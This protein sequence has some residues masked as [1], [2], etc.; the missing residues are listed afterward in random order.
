MVDLEFLPYLPE[1]F[2]HLPLSRV[3]KLAQMLVN[4]A[5][6]VHFAKFPLHFCKSEAHLYAVTAL[7]YLESALEKL[8]CPCHTVEF[9]CFGYLQVQQLI[10]IFSILQLFATSIIDFHC[11][12]EKSKVF[13]VVSIH[14]VEDFSML[15]W[16]L[17]QYLLKEVSNSLNFGIRM[18]LN[19]SFQIGEP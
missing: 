17:V 4:S 2:L 1:L 12:V 11:M 5:C 18:P 7:Y 8:P 16:N 19:N 3:A 15:G 14:I 9:G 10:A 13:F 6:S